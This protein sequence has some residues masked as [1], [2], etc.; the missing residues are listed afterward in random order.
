MKVTLTKNI[1]LNSAQV[2]LRFQKEELRK[3]VQEYLNGKHFEPFIENRIKDYL[4]NIG[5][6]DE[7][8]QLTK[9][10]SAVKDSGK[11]FVSEEGKY[12]IWFTQNDSL[13][14]NKIL[15][16]RRLLPN[17]KDE[18]RNQISLDRK[19]H[20]L[21]PTGE[22]EYTK[23][24]LISDKIHGNI[25]HSND[26]LHFSWVWDN[27]E[28]SNY[29]FSGQLGKSER[30]TSIKNEEIPS[31]KEIQK[32]I[33]EM[34]PEWAIEQKRY[35]IR[36]NKLNEESRKIFEAKNFDFKWNDFEVQIHNLPLMPYDN[37]EA[38]KWRN[39]LLI[40]EAKKEYLNVTDFE[41][42]ALELNEKEALLS[43]NLD[44]PKT[45]DFIEKTDSKKVFWHLH[46]PMELNPNTKIKLSRKSTQHIEIKEG[47]KISFLEI[48]EKMNFEDTENSFFLYYD[49]F[50]V[51][52]RQHRAVSAMA[53]AFDCNKK[54]VIT[55]MT[56][57]E[58]SSDYISKNCPDIKMRE[59]RTIFKTDR[60]EHDRYIIFGNKENLKIWN[61][62][63]SIDYINF[64]DLKKIDRNSIGTIR[65]SI[66]FTPISKD[67]LKTDFLNF[68]NSEIKNDN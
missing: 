53:D 31:D 24:N 51:Q 50:V 4:K 45:K 16:F 27:L 29:I 49:K 67:M 23:L 44:I 36:F 12:Q 41:E 47:T 1:K 48:A 7:Q 8:Y 14:K 19:G 46:A 21:L 62:P 15:Y 59:L 37:E 43:F 34:L 64:S 28:K 13:F 68:I 40:E 17:S 26:Q 56:P 33:S 2:Y 35:R 60:P 3:D 57:K 58:K 42:K 38:K 54:I 18:I 55:D 30:Q 61:I 63:N 32:T 25:N 52:E 39:W 11:M 5:V 10:G 20:F 66:V 65:Q 9:L 6:F 22:T